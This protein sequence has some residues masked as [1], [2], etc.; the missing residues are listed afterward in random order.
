MK[1]LKQ[2]RWP[3]SRQLA[4][5][6][7]GIVFCGLVLL[8]L[9]FAFPPLSPKT[10]SL[11]YTGVTWQCPCDAK[12]PVKEADLEVTIMFNPK[13]NTY[14]S[15]FL[16]VSI[17]L[18]KL[19]SRSIPFTPSVPIPEQNQLISGDPA[20]EY[21]SS[22]FEAQLSA[23]S[24]D[25][26][27]Q[28][29]SPQSLALAQNNKV[30]FGWTITPKYD[31]PQAILVSISVIDRKGAHLLASRQIRVAVNKTPTEVPSPNTFFSL[32][33]VTLSELLI[34]LLGSILNI[35]WLIEHFR[36]KEA[37]SSAPRDRADKSSSSILSSQ[38]P[39]KQTNKA[40]ATE[41]R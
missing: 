24:F 28:I 22:Q 20:E 13:L 35:P 9:R 18:N 17:T 33:Q 15:E 30:L 19:S 27:P 38:L 14:R 1:I 29:Q 16:F 7:W 11:F 8:S 6:G 3:S 40:P 2:Q 34:I 4:C 37:K 25:V 5:I 31:G 41:G 36:R 26:D 39:S 32:G 21:A 23:S 12:N 10:S